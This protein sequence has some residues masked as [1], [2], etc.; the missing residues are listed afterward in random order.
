[1]LIVFPPEHKMEVS[2]ALI[3]CHEKF[4]SIPCKKAI[5]SRKT[6]EF[7]GKQLPAG[8]PMKREKRERKGGLYECCTSFLTIQSISQ[9][10]CG[11]MKNL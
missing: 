11:R 7:P 9:S 3:F 8:E 5:S 4:Y 10:L 2:I 1:M 6:K